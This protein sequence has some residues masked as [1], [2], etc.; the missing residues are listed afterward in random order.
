[1]GAL[2]DKL[3]SESSVCH[4][5]LVASHKLLRAAASLSLQVQEQRVEIRLD[6]AL[7]EKSNFEPFFT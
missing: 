3:S 5:L 6:C 4:T 2:A 1:M 7:R